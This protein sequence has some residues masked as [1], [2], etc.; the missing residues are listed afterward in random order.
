MANGQI[1]KYLIP[2]GLPLLGFLIGA[3]TVYGVMKT[4]VDNNSKEINTLRTNQSV[5]KTD[6]ATIKSDIQWIRE[7]MQR[8]NIR[9]NSNL[10]SHN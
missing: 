9:F 8:N 7:Y 6:I 10:E 5:V 4:N 1:A 3:A 2:V